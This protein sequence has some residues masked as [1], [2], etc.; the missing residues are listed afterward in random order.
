MSV[1]AEDQDRPVDL[2]EELRDARAARLAYLEHAERQYCLLRDE[3]RLYLRCK[4]LLE[5]TQ[6]Q[7]DH[8]SLDGSSHTDLQDL[9]DEKAEVMRNLHESEAR[10]K[11]MLKDP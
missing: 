5:H 7:L 4:Q 6:F 11:I 8:V 1:V 3:T 9:L 10:L 2:A